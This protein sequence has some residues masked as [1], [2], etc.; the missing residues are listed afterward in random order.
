MQKTGVLL[1]FISIMGKKFGHHLN[2]FFIMKKQVLFIQGGGDDGYAA[3]AK[4]VDSLKAALGNGY[5]VRY[6]QMQSDESVSDYGWPAQIGK[7]INDVEEEVI[8]VGH[9]LGASL[10]LKYLSETKVR[11]K[12]SGIFLIATPFWSGDEEWVRGLILRQDFAAKLPGNTPIFLYH[13]K[14]DEEVPFEHLSL[15]AQRLP[16]ARVHEIEKGG[17]QIN[18]DLTLVAGDIKGL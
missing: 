5:E 9:S 13:S 7:E 6:P 2:N 4:M 10:I 16:Q 1:L 18:E 11:K 14:D 17:H 15:Y 8:L 12:I 3:D